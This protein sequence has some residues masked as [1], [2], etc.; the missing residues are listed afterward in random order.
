MII[1]SAAEQQ[2]STNEQCLKESRPFHNDQGPNRFSD[3]ARFSG[4]KMGRF[5]GS[6]HVGWKLCANHNNITS[7]LIRSLPAHEGPPNC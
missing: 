4:R 3:F 5:S 2:S 7:N 6:C 1:L